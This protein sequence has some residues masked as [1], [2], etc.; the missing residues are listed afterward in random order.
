MPLNA[1]N[2]RRYRRYLERTKIYEILSASPP[3]SPPTAERQ[4]ARSDNML[5]A[6]KKGRLSEGRR[7]KKGQS[8]YVRPKAQ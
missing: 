8:G 4:R 5:D 3:A 6:Y 1:C 7:W 2:D